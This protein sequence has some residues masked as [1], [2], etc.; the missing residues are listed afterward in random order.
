MNIQKSDI[1]RSNIFVDS[2][3][4]PIFMGIG[5]L[6][7]WDRPYHYETYCWTLLHQGH[8]AFKHMIILR[9][10]QLSPR[11]FHKHTKNEGGSFWRRLPQI[12][13]KSLKFEMVASS[14]VSYLGCVGRFCLVTAEP[15]NTSLSIHP[16]PNEPSRGVPKNVNFVLLWTA[17]C[18]NWF[19]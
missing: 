4:S 8:T 10:N 12:W 9:R 11:F 19:Q 5:P 6:F 14:S 2:S 17:W 18:F 13:W 15:W 7:S 1:V 16:T 3:L